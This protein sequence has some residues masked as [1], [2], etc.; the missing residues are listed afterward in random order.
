MLKIIAEPAIL[1]NKI[2]SGE[3]ILNAIFD[4]TGSIANIHCTLNNNRYVLNFDFIIS[5]I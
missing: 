3:K 2:T 5:E 4:N 1:K